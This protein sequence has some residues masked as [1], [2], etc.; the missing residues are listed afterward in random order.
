[1]PAVSAVTDHGDGLAVLVLQAGGNGHAQRCTDRSAGVADIKVS[2]S[3]SERRGKAATP[4][5]WRKV[6]IC[7]RRPVRILC[8]YA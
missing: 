8:G 6:A 2:Y 5:F 1:M 4:S 3:L 7:S